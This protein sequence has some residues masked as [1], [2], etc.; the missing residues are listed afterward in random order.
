M[1]LTL[2]LTLTLSAEGQGQGW[3][4]IDTSDSLVVVQSQDQAENEDRSHRQD[5]CHEYDHHGIGHGRVHDKGV[6]D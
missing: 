4:C 2:A 1:T 5:C 6:E 3:N